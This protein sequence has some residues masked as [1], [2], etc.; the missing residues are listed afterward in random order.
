MRNGVIQETQVKD[1]YSRSNLRERDWSLT[2][3]DHGSNPEIEALSIYFEY[4]A[5]FCAANDLLDNE[6]QLERD[7]WDS[8]E[9]WLDSKSITWNKFWISDLVDPIPLQEKFW[10]I[11][12]DKFDKTWRDNINEDKFDKEIGFTDL[13]D[14]DFIIPHGFYKRYIGEN[15]ESIYIRSALVSEKGSEA[16]LRAFQTAK[17]H[18]DYAFPI[19]DDG[20]RFEINQFGLTY[21]SWLK[22]AKGESEGLDKHDY[23][24][25]NIGY[26]IPIIGERIQNLFPLEY[27]KDLKKGFFEKKRI[28]VYENWNE[29]TDRRYRDNKSDRK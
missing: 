29:V 26:S 10:K 22:Y 6:P 18:H 11:E 7:E 13:Y 14:D 19:E 9:H 15:T 21:E 12:Y 23:L 4:H 8:W 24:Y 2:R 1:D 27:S 3:N 20:E 5:M 25:K 17:N 28:S 16:L